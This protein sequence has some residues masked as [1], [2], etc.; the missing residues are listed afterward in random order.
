MVQLGG[1]KKIS[2]V[3]GV[4]KFLFSPVLHQLVEVLLH[5]L[6]DEVEVIVLSDH[7]LQF[8]HVGMVELLQGLV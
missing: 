3:F 2:T 5:V 4:L 1:D 8:H 7:L 6:E